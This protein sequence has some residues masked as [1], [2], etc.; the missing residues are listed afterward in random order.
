MG[1]DTAIG[2]MLVMIAQR[3]YT[4]KKKITAIYILR[5]NSR[6]IVPKPWKHIKQL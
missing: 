4:T 3:L 5:D 2:T 1:F 6:S